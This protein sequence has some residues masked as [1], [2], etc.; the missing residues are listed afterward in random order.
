MSGSHEL[1]MA[2]WD[3]ECAIREVSGS[4]ELGMACWDQEC[5]IRLRKKSETRMTF[6]K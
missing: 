1:V 4:H 3:Q 6:N 2:C 5:S